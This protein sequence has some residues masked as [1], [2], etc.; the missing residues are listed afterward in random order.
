ML[1]RRLE[2]ERNT[3]TVRASLDEATFAAAWAAGQA[4][5]L[6]Q[7]IADALQLE[8]APAEVLSVGVS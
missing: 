8:P 4:M 3:A 2:F 1:F 7:V 5:L 6:E